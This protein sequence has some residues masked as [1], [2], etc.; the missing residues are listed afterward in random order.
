VHLHNPMYLLLLLIYT[1]GMP[2]P[3][4]SAKMQAGHSLAPPSPPFSL[5]FPQTE[6]SREGNILSRNEV[7]RTTT[8][9]LY[10][11]LVDVTPARLVPPGLAYFLPDT[12]LFFPGSNDVVGDRRGGPL[13]S[14]NTGY[15]LWRIPCF[16]ISVSSV[17]GGRFFKE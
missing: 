13:I 5:F 2:P 15:P 11:F 10:P 14:S 12:R 4:C 7:Q 6:R 3:E 1:T 17:W 9:P 8:S 16:P